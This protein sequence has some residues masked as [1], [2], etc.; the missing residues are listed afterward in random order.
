MKTAEVTNSAL[1]ANE[2]SRTEADLESE[3]ARLGAV[4]KRIE[5]G[6]AP[7]RAVPTPAKAPGKEFSYELKLDGIRCVAM[8]NGRHVLL[9]NRHGREITRV[10]PEVVQELAELAA[11]RIIVDGE[12]VALD[13]KGRPNFQRIAE[14][15]HLYRHMDIRRV[16]RQIPAH[17]VV[18]DLLSI[19]DYDIRLLPL[20]ARRKLLRG[21]LP[22]TNRIR[23]I[24][25]FEGDPAPL[26]AFCREHSLE[27]IVAKRTE[28]PYRSGPSRS[29]DWVKLKIER[30]DDF[31]IVGYTLGEGSR[32]RMGAIDVAS[33]EGGKLVYRS[34][35]GSGLDDAAID[36]LLE[37][38]APLHTDRPTAVGEYHLAPRGRVHVRPEVVVSVKYAGFSDGDGLRFPVYRG[39]R[40]DVLPE[41]CTA[42]PN[43]DQD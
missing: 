23:I 1:T 2:P 5:M 9:Y 6:F 28:S 31:V 8:K 24:D 11:P 39:I 19:G 35:V 29:D 33:F 41:E 16:S 40:E 36:V 38:L 26:L 20:S 13:E 3:A 22:E 10:Y 42:A 4:Q 18:F 27:G 21:A 37:R 43:V 32:A 7:M 15:A 14:R 34:K 12:V 25:V 17:Y 30:D